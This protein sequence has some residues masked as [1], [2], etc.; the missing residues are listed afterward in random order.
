MAVDD[1]QS[2]E[3]GA[4][5]TVDAGTT[6]APPLDLRLHHML[7]SL[8][9]QHGLRHGD[10]QRYRHY[11]TRRLAR[12]RKAGKAT[13]KGGKAFATKD[14]HTLGS[15][16]GDPAA[17]KMEHLLLLLLN[18]ERAWAF[19]MQ[20]KQDAASN[21]HM[22]SYQRAHLLRRLRRAA[23]WATRLQGLVGEA[24]GR[25]TKRTSLEV[26]AYA[27][28]MSA[29]VDVEQE[30]WGLALGKLRTAHSILSQLGEVGSPEE[31]DLFSSKAEE[32]MQ[33][34]RFC[35]Y[36]LGE[37][38]LE[39]LQQVQGE[40][41]PQAL[42][43]KLEAVMEASRTEAATGLEAVEWGGRRLPVSSAEVRV[44]LVKVDEARKRLS[45]SEEDEDEEETQKQEQEG[46]R[47]EAY[48][49]VYAAYDEASKRVAEAVCKVEGMSHGA[50]VDAQK[51][52][53]RLLASYLRHGKLET[54]RLRKEGLVQTLLRG[55]KAG[56][57]GE[58]RGRP[59]DLV[60]VLDAL[61]QNAVEVQALPGVEELEPVLMHAQA[62]QARYRAQRAFYLAEC[63]AGGKR[64]AEAVA[65]FAK[66]EDLGEVAVG[67]AK[68]VVGKA[69][70]E[71]MFKKAK[72][73]KEMAAGG[74]C[75]TQALA[76]LVSLSPASVGG[77][78]SEEAAL[79]VALS[80]LSL[81]AATAAAAAAAAE[82]LEG[83]GA[84]R[85]SKGMKMLHQKKGKDKQSQQQPGKTT[86]K[87]MKGGSSGGLEAG[88]VLEPAS[89]TL[90]ERLGEVD[91][92]KEISGFGI[93]HMPPTVTPVRAKP[94][95]F[96]M[97]FN[98]LEGRL[99][100]LAVKAGLPPSKKADTPGGEG[101]V[102]GKG[103]FGWLRG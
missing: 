95:V 55:G 94:Q 53:L 29:G 17:V 64:L 66:A 37:G 82:R 34:A 2:N 100:D 58:G 99:P 103:L 81:S 93:A 12:I 13:H 67:L 79:T 91:G 10:Y 88:I 4:T 85:G 45:I 62:L 68:E 74:R 73:V 23:V 80:A 48:S 56:G 77:A 28:W 97:A 101:A 8:Q 65:L 70:K 57:K 11:V 43:E 87:V 35:Q 86:A 40:H 32:V 3:N 39:E 15:M 31:Q 59:E 19:S 18:A 46:Q 14:V 22:P 98:F 76:L 21:Q 54:M 9:L 96:D 72:E 63:H 7:R 51:E 49:S 27:G 89:R 20:L 6:P 30:Q 71:E 75:R 38:S 84:E 16:G 24:S 25:V 102:G 90:L 1:A 5:T 42:R 78:G 69:Q 83:E 92:G 47:E 52:E 26:A 60:H 33:S 61:M 41:V 44:A 50:R 36:N